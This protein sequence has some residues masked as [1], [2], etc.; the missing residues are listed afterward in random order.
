ML[1]PNR[2]TSSTPD[3][4]NPALRQ[5]SPSQNSP[6]VQHD[7]NPNDSVVFQF[8]N[9]NELPSAGPSSR[10]STPSSAYGGGGNGVGGWIERMNNVQHRSTIPQ[11]KRRKTED[12]DGSQ[13]GANAA[14]RG[15]SGILGEYV[16]DKRKEANGS[17]ASQALTVDLTS[18]M[19]TPYPF[20]PLVVT[21]PY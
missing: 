5:F 18:G 1:Q 15:G 7:P 20:H 14:P 19:T 8:S 3:L 16:K 2:R 11:A 13:D 6:R 12:Q 9:P 17:T 10:A 21:N 4:T